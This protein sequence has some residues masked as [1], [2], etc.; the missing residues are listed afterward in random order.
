MKVVTDHLKAQEMCNEAVHVEPLSLAHV[1]DR[2]KTQNT[3]NEVVRNKL[4]MILFVP[5]HFKT[6]EMCNEIMRAM[7]E[8]FTVFLTVLKHKRCVKKLLR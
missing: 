7:P 3:G 6:R 5:G 8:H 2:F 1:P 4:C